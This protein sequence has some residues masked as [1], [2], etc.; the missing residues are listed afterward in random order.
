MREWGH[1][2]RCA[3]L[4]PWRKLILAG[5][6]I[7]DAPLGLEGS[8][9]TVMLISH[10]VDDALLGAAGEPDLGT[11]YPSSMSGISDASQHYFLG[12]GYA[13]VLIKEKL[14]LTFRL[15]I[16][17]EAQYQRLSKLI[18]CLR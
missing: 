2:L 8:I 18:D 10:A 13:T 17:L 3:P 11:L 7:P 5:H 1:G 15:D 9:Q 6:L 4:R 14:E 16:T 12:R